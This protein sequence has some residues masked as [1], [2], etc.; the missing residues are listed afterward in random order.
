MSVAALA[1]APSS[2]DKILDVAEGLFA[3]R[4]YSGVGMRE[5][6]DGVGLGK[7]SVFH[8][9]KSK[10]ELYSA[11]CIRILATIERALVGSLAIGG[12]PTL[13]LERCIGTL[14]DVLVDHPTYARLLLR[15]M[16]ED[17]DLPRDGPE[18]ES[19]HRAIG[20][21]LEPM[22]AL[23][24]E[25]MAAGELRVASVPHVLILLVGSMVFPFASG[26]FGHELLGADVFERDQVRRLKREALDLVRAGVGATHG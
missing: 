17:D 9:F 23:L 14:V 3:R 6:A 25:G 4:G 8:H 10:A 15:S 21:V 26:D 20:G 16:F 12:K 18:S 24:R 11:V 7:S 13:R 2:R 1:R 5:V 19:V 22:A